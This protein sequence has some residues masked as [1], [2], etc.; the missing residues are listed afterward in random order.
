MQL[1]TAL[2]QPFQTPLNDQ[3]AVLRLKNGSLQKEK[4]KLQERADQAEAAL[5]IKGRELDDARNALENG[6]Q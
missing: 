2:S 3:V 6:P 5:R 4:E 1:E